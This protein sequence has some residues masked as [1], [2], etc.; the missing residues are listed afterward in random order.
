[1]SLTAVDGKLASITGLTDGYSI[2]VADLKDEYPLPSELGS[3]VFQTD[4]GSGI[5]NYSAVIT[6]DSTKSGSFVI[7]SAGNEHQYSSA[8]MVA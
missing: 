2:S 6:D 3:V 7:E 8:S 5:I 4:G 1:M